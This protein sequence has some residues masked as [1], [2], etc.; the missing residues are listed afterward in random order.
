MKLVI[1]TSHYPYKGEPFLED[2]LRVAER[3]FSEILIV[4]ME[5]KVTQETQ[6]IPYNAKIICVRAGTNKYSGLGMAVLRL[7]TNEYGLKEVITGIKERGWGNFHQTAV[8]ILSDERCVYYLEKNQRKWLNK[9]SQN[10]LYYSYWLSGAATYLARHKDR[11]NSLCISRTHGSECFYNQGYHPFRINQLNKLDAVISVSKAGREDIL[12]HYSNV[13]ENLKEKVF[14][15][16]LGVTKTNNII[17]PLNRS[18]QITIVS[19]SNV[20][21]VKRIDLLIDALSMVKVPHIHWI[22]FGDGAELATMKKRA[23]DK[24]GQNIRWEF[25]GFKKKEEILKYYSGTSIKLFINCSD[26][27]GIPVSIMEA[28]SYGIPVIARNVGGTGELVDD[29]C[30]KLLPADITPKL[31]AD[32]ISNIVQRNTKDYQS[33]RQNAYMKYETLFSAEKNY[34][35][36]YKKIISLQSGSMLNES[37]TMLV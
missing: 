16:Y 27:E 29:T 5:K 11:I 17:N 3:F 9:Y 18:E 10:T 35:D 30:G 28:M 24:L 6:Y 33:L 36:F 13:I 37:G 1:F 26:S 14:V 8:S 25:T 4:S 2:E 19:C 22:H 34:R 7:L 23:A 32:A 21:P 20:I 31:L 12:D 15:S